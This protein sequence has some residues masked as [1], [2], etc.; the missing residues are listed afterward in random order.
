VARV[1]YHL[2][3]RHNLYAGR[4]IHQGYQDAFADGGH[5]FETFTSQQQLG[6]AL[7]SFRPDL[8]ITGTHPVY[9]RAL[10]FA[11]LRAWRDK[12]LV[13]LVNAEPLDY[14]PDPSY[15][16]GRRGALVSLIRSGGFGDA[17]FSFFQPERM[18]DFEQA[19]GQ[20]HHTVLLA[21]NKL[22]HFPVTPRPE[23]RSDAVFIGA[24]LP[25]KR[26]TF[27][28]LLFPLRK[29]YDVRIYGQDWTL[30]DRAIGFVQ[31]VS[32]YFNLR[33]FDRLRGL[34]VP[35]D[36][37]RAIYSSTKIGINIHES[38]Q[39][40]LGEDFNERTLKILAC[41]AFELCDDV[42]V[43]RRYFSTDELVTANDAEW[44][45]TF[46]HY[47]RSDEERRRIQERGRAKVLAQ[48]TYHNRVTQLLEL[49]DSV[50][51]ARVG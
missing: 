36:L 14:P 26:A 21:A 40:E 30:R 7:E 34:A 10:D 33:L 11:A 4:F 39:R 49:C 17:Y 50:R 12:G 2:P 19:T 1:L 38:Q 27:R 5:A 20:P 29:S 9:T 6:A 18:R 25:R 24:Y 51:R 15:S 44:L 43:I 47:L 28:R 37:E 35:L 46:E 8:L 31:R 3:N 22:R 16:L 41:G 48:H 45:P 13:A 42:A 23:L 32:Q